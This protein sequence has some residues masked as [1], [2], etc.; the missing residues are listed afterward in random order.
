VRLRR[1]S[2][3]SGPIV[4]ADALVFDGAGRVV[5]ITRKN[6][7]CRGQRAFPGTLVLG[8][9][10]PETALVRE[11]KDETNL[12][13]EIE[14]AL[15]TYDAPRRD[16]RGRIVSHAFVCRLGPGPQELRCRED[17]GEGRFVPLAELQG[18]DLAFDHED[19]LADARRLLGR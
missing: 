2:R 18:E 19:M 14:R 16:P 13:I 5:V 11:V 6:P 4:G 17:A 1:E 8:R 15:G 7:P 3:G 10:P 9:E 12:D